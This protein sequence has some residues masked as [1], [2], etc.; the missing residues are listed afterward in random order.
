MI[1]AAELLVLGFLLGYLINEIYWF[2]KMGHGFV[3][4]SQIRQCLRKIRQFTR[5]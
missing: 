3:L 5:L 4:A 1:I 2:R